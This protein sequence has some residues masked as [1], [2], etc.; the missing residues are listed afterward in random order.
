MGGHGPA[1]WPGAVGLPVSPFPTVVAPD[2]AL[3]RSRVPLTRSLVVALLPSPSGCPQ[4]ALWG[5]FRAWV[6][7]VVAKG[8]LVLLHGSH[9][10]SPSCEAIM[11]DFPGVCELRCFFCRFWGSLGHVQLQFTGEASTELF[12]KEC[13]LDFLHGVGLY[14]GEPAGH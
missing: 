9:R 3:G 4:A 6:P 5:P 2:F 8:K 7:I 13:L 14:S 10:P 12:Q 1:D 11:N